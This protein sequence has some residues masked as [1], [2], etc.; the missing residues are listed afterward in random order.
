[1]KALNLY[2]KQDARY[3]EVELPVIENDDDVL[4]KVQI[5]GICGSDI[6][7]FGK[8]GSYNPGLTWGH[9]FSGIISAVGKSVSLLKESDRV[10]VC[11]CFP[12]NQ[13]EFCQQGSFSKCT[14]LQVLGGHKKGAFAEYIKVPS[15]NVIKIPATMDFETASFV[16]PSSVVV[17][18]Y[19]QINIKAGHRVAVVG[20]GTIGLLA[21]QW[22]KVFGAYEV[23]AFDTDDRKLDIARL[24]GADH[25][26]NVSEE[27]FLQKFMALTNNGGVEVV[28]ESSGST[29]GIA[30]ALSLAKK[31]GCVLLLGIPYGDVALPRE[32]FEKIIRNELTLSGSWNSISTPFPGSEWQTSLKYMNNGMIVVKPLITQRITLQQAPA[33]FPKLYSREVFFIKV[34]MKIA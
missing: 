7:R 29:A 12:C 20:C 27:A 17:H 30:N 13:C 33:L 32:N 23:H 3:E 18:G 14:H 28:V 34:L 21:V 4:I 22:A 25:T 6:S 19:N 15:A 26:F 9:E 1:M 8:I 11:P 2:G 16:E 31:G 24:T 5:A 10:I